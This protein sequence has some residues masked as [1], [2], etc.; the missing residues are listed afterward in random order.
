MCLQVWLSQAVK[1]LAAFLLGAVSGL[2]LWSR[3]V[4]RVERQFPDPQ[5]LIV[6]RVWG[7]ADDG[8]VW[9]GPIT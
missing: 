8:T 3:I 7:T 4:I 5:P 9:S 2:Y 1:L 6:T